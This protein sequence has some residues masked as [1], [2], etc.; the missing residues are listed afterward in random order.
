MRGVLINGHGTPRPKTVLIKI[1]THL[2]D[3]QHIIPKYANMQTQNGIE[4]RETGN[5]YI[6]PLDIIFH[7]ALFPL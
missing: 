6:L 7:T 2:T 4:Y 5:N 3:K 1:R